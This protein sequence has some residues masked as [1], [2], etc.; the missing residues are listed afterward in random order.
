MTNIFSHRE[1]YFLRHGKREL[2]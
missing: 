2:Q 1:E